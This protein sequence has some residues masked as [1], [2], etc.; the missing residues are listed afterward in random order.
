MEGVQPASSASSLFIND[1]TGQAQRARGEAETPA[2][3]G[4]PP[5][6]PRVNEGPSTVIT[7]SDRAREL[8]EQERAEGTDPAPAPSTTPLPRNADAPPQPDGAA[9]DA[10]TRPEPPS[11]PE[12][13][14]RLVE[15]RSPNEFLRN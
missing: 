9:A 4:A 12:S 13:D 10:S 8:A 3:G 14:G 15:D 5:E 7:I 1:S 11:P 2:P 6:P